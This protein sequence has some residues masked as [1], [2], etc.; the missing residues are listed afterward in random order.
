MGISA[1]MKGTSTAMNNIAK[2]Y[3]DQAKEMFP[4]IEVDA[5][6]KATIIVIKGTGLKL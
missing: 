5:G 2:F 6:R 1:G 4:I 3:L